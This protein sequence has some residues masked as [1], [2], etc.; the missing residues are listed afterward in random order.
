MNKFNVGDVIRFSTI[1]SPFTW[2]IIEWREYRGNTKDMSYYI[3]LIR[4]DGLHQITTE[5]SLEN[6]FTLVRP[7]FLPYDPAQQKDED[8]DI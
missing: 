8:D 4:D 6:D 1:P 5:F 3:P 7:G 2:T